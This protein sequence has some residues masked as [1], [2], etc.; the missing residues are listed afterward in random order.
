MAALR[1]TVDDGRTAAPDVDGIH[2]AALPASHL[3]MGPAM[4]FRHLVAKTQ[5]IFTVA[6]LASVLFWGIM[7]SAVPAADQ[8]PASDGPPAIASGTAQRS[9]PVAVSIARHPDGFRL[10]RDGRP[11]FIKGIGG[12]QHL[13]RAVA[14]GANSLRSWDARGAGRLL[15]QAMHHHM[16]VTLGIW[17]SHR[18][19]DYQD[20]AYKQR[21][22]RKVAQLAERHRS[23]PALLIWALGNEINLEGA[24]TPAAWRFINDL[25]GLIKKIDPFHPVISVIAY[26]P[27]ACDMV[28]SYAPDLDA[29]G[30]NAYGALGNL[31]TMIDASSFDG[32][33]IVTEWGVDGHWESAQT[34]WDR[35]IEPT[36]ARKAAE[37]LR[38]YRDNILANSDRC[39]GAY[40]F[41]WGQKQERTPTWYSMFIETLPGIDGVTPAACATVDAM[42]YN[43]SG[44]WPANRAPMVDRMTINGTPSA[45]NL[46]LSPGKPLLARVSASDPDGDGLQ[47]I[48]ELMAEPGLL[49]TGG[50]FE[51]RPET[52]GVPVDG[53]LPEVHILAPE[54]S[55]EYR[56]YVYVLDN[57]G[58]VGTANVPFRVD[59]S[60]IAGGRPDTGGAHPAG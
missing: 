15:D 53:N 9:T 13:D 27:A 17:L 5:R 44:T 39:I 24:G 35:P 36:S 23:H 1:E 42:H 21:V 31:R 8:P 55:G 20:P 25:A 14:A 50:S 56:L 49:G 37:H 16:T 60:T 2:A 12:H 18:A 3:K 10:Y 58:H 32:P 11:Y 29:L 59:T 52:L 43:W 7:A 4:L 22:R 57:S 46:S 6:G 33:Y 54:A 30:I 48:W 45:G 40:V 26:D 19:A 28:A 38:R 51:P 47:Y 41:L 34:S